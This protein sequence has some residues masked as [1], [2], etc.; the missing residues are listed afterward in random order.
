LVA[1]TY[2]LTV[3]DSNLCFTTTSVT[4]SEPTALTLTATSTDALCNGSSDGTATSVVNGGTTPYAY[5]W[6]NGISTGSVTGLVVGTYDL[7]VTDNNLCNATTSVTISEP[8]A[9][10]LT[11]SSTDAL[12]NGSSDGTAASIVNGGTTPYAY[13]WSNGTSTGSVT[14]LVAGTY[15]L[16]VTDNNLCNLTTSVTISEPTALSLTA[17]STDALCNGSSDG[18]A[19]SVVNGGTTP[20][21]YNW[22]NGT[23]TGSVTGLVAATYNLT[24][25]D[26]NLCNLTISVTISEPTALTLTASSTDALCKGSNDG[27]AT[28]I[29]NGGTTPYT[30]NWSNAAS[31]SSVNSLV[32]G[33]H[34][35]T[36]TDNNLCS[37]TISVTISE[38]MALTLT[39]SSTNALCAGSNDGTA[40]SIVNGGTAPY[41]YN[42]S[43][44]KVTANLSDLFIG[45]YDLTVTDN[46]FCIKTTSVTISE[47]TALTLTA[48]S[49]DAL[50]NGSTDETATS[51]INGGTAPYAYAWS[52][53]TS[54]GSVTSLVAAIYNLTV[55]DN[56]LCN[57][58]T[59]VTISEPTEVKVVAVIYNV[60]CFGGSNGAIKLN[61]T[62]GSAP[63]NYLWDEGSTTSII[64]SLNKNSYLVTVTDIN[65][66]PIYKTNFVLE[67]IA[68]LIV[69]I[70]NLTSTACY[71][72]NNGSAETNVT[73]GTSPYSYNW[74]NGQLN[75]SAAGL[76][77]GSSYNVRVLDANGCIENIL[78][79]IS[80]PALITG[81]DASTICEG[82]SI[83]VGGTYLSVQ[84]LHNVR[85]VA[86]NGC[87]SILK[88]DL[89]VIPR[90]YDT[91]IVQLCEFDTYFAQGAEQMFTGYYYD[92]LQAITSC[93]SI[94]VTII[95][96]V[97]PTLTRIDVELCSGDSIL[98]SGN[99]KFTPGVFEDVYAGANG[100]DSVV[101][102]NLTFAHP[103][104]EGVISG[105]VLFEGTGIESGKVNLIRKEGNSPQSMYTVDST[106]VNLNGEYYFDNIQSGNYMVKAIGDTSL[107]ANGATYADSTN[108]WQKSTIYKINDVCFA[109]TLFG[110]DINLIDFT[111]NIGFGSIHAR[112]VRGVNSIA[113]EPIPRVDI[114]LEKTPTGTIV[115]G[116]VS[117]ELG[118]LTF[119]SIEQGA[120]RLNIDIPGYTTD[121]VHRFNFTE[122]NLA[123]EVVICVIDS[124]NTIEICEKSIN[125]SIEENTDLFFAVYPNPSNGNINIKYDINFNDQAS[126][127]IYDVIG[128]KI[129]RFKLIAS[130][131][132]QKILL[133]SVLSSGIYS[134]KYLVNGKLIKTDKLVIKK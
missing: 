5:N 62:G 102:T 96:L 64:S 10:S 47:P 29:V 121:T 131:N 89:T 34:D 128:K 80:H 116:G 115:D 103:L 54:T 78:T 122:A 39:V 4:M 1:G 57:T 7:T 90:K 16:T 83:Q 91:T 97:R 68:P 119:R 94:I 12:C 106:Y 24:V 44:G 28:S 81:T 101:W 66:C 8:T 19:T 72:G 71:Q 43:N 86:A 100:C 77:G 74:S 92:T 35:L 87:D 110:V 99:Y 93:D 40:T 14:G 133:N 55:T 120:Y 37:A 61:V 27:T 109:D 23:S 129:I 63:Y 126:F 67:P 32:L 49:T 48:S 30:Y 25:T 50:C 98:L 18:A 104:I 11:A 130:A 75:S 31:T 53:G 107:Y 123:Y 84:G 46:N 59:S 124:N 9:L 3:T 51:V 76:I 45:T 56:N 88:L 20:Y 58:A 2:D 6:S 95:Y 82:D 65:L 42:W 17:S 15:D 113:G 79:T 70:T 36:I 41:A 73:G 134:Y 118:E 22:S 105:V 33:I 108:H 52:N 69:S 117:D 60:N 13:N 111:A 21:T 114:A 125:T 38:P 26:N 112:I 85:L 127:E 132:Q